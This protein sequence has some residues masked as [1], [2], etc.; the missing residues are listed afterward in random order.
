MTS[1]SHDVIRN[2]SG[3]LEYRAP[4]KIVPHFLGEEFVASL[5]QFAEQQQANF[6]ESK[7]GAHE[8]SAVKRITGFLVLGSWRFQR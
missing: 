8:H 6:K 4:Y 3:A 2:P 5:L 1:F 7:V